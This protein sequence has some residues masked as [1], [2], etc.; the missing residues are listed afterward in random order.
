MAV[1]SLWRVKGQ[2]GKVVNY[3]ANP[4]KTGNPALG[5]QEISAV[6]GYAMSQ[7]KTAVFGN[8]GEEILS[9]Q[10]QSGRS[11]RFWCVVAL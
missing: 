9:I 7:E 1:T 6:I 2:I 10:L 8:E 3:A 11:K 4:E 5:E